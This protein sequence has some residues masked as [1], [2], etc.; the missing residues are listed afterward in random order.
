[1]TRGSL[2]RIYQDIL[3]LFRQHDLKA[4][5]AFVAAF[6]MT[7][8]ERA[9]FEDRFVDIDYRGRNWLRHY[10]ADRAR[11]DADS[12]FCPEAFEMA[13]EHGHEIA[14]HGFCHVP[15][16]DTAMPRE[17]LANEVASA[18]AVAQAKGLKLETF[19]YPRNL[20][21]HQTVLRD[22][23]FKG[24]RAS[25]GGSRRSRFLREFN[26]FERAQQHGEE[27]DGMIRIPPGYFF[28]WRKGLR[29]GVPG[30]V[31]V[32]R[33]KSVLNTAVE[34]GEVAHLWFHPHNLLSGPKT[35][36]TLDEVITVASRLRDR[37]KLNVLTQAEYVEG[38]VGCSHA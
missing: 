3:Q 30:T 11:G 19:I 2:I 29:A 17:Y 28:N 35:I 36:E 15:F 12:W 18:V 16:D 33:W 23:G 7:K 34:R 25:L 38:Y 4:T 8:E 9:R 31:M 10:R 6:T 1:M 32:A 5:F 21:A 14:S 26:L 20:V 13:R 24:Y 22:F 37:G 27:V